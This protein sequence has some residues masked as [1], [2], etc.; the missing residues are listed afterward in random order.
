M[1]LAINGQFSHNLVD[2]IETVG[3]LVGE[4][5]EGKGELQYEAPEI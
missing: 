3:V 5:S 2:R 4:A 1:M